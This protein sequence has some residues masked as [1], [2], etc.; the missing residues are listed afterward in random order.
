MMGSEGCSTR[1]R[2][3]D[4]SE[5]ALHT[6]QSLGKPVMRQAAPAVAT[7]GYIPAL[8]GLRAVAIILVLLGH[9]GLGRVVPG[10]FGVT[11]FFLISGFLI[12]RLLLVEYVESGKIDYLRFYARR[13]ARLAP[14]LVVVI[15][16]VTAAYAAL[17]T[18]VPWSE[19]VA[20][21]LYVINYYRIFHAVDIIPLGILW[22]L[23]VEEHFY[24]VF[25]LAFAGLLRSQRVVPALITAIAVALVWRVVLVLVLHASED[26]TY[27]ATD[28][29][30]D[31]ILYGAL[32]AILA[33]RWAG[34]LPLRRLMAPALSLLAILVLLST[35]VIRNPVLR[36]TVRYSVQGLA[37]DAARRGHRLQRSPA[38]ERAAG[39]VRRAAARLRRQAQLLPLPLALFRP[40]GRRLPAAD[41][42]PRRQTACVARLRD[43]H[44]PS[45]LFRGRTVVPH[46]AQAARV[47]CALT[48][49]RSRR[50]TTLPS[51]LEGHGFTMTDFA[52]A[53]ALRS[54]RAPD[55]AASGR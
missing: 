39:D 3:G 41:G 44:E 29:R 22:S 11:V 20:A 40:G 42:L 14:A 10:G 24:L 17:H 26:Y 9:F 38:R 34:A 7:R 18:I 27:M 48:G 28:A 2:R 19:V 55:V 4:L 50:P 51:A 47:P 12:T 33:H 30:F 21:F 8:D 36:E 52:F 1:V 32:L 53:P 35:F 25:P 13:F 31:S 23:A 49:W 6:G 15:A 37:P 45:L 54:P 43:R 5:A 16:S 46:L